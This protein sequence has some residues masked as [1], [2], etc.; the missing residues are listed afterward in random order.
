MPDSEH[1]LTTFSEATF[2]RPYGVAYRRVQRSSTSELFKKALETPLSGMTPLGLAWNMTS[3]RYTPA[4][5]EI[6]MS[7]KR[8]FDGHHRVD[9]VV[10]KAV[11][12]T[13]P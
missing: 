9:W 11:F 1:L 8:P 7:H 6:T 5:L 13:T 12:A 4:I 3:H 2:P 10:I